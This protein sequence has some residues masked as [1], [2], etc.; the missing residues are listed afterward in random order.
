MKTRCYNKNREYYY[1]YGERGI[2][3]CN[4]WMKDSWAFVN[5]AESNGYSK[6]LYID[7]IDPNGDYSPENCRWVTAS[8]NAQNTRLLSKIN[9]TG[10]RG[11]RYKPQNNGRIDYRAHITSNGK[12]IS[13]GVYRTKEEAAKAYNNFVIDNKTLHP[14]NPV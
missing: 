13:L 5:W 4:E 12:S 1:L 6:G 8:E 9:T 7:R 2:R 3:V 10:F 14:L 11:V